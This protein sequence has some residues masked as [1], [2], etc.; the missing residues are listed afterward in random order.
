M[1]H[2]APPVCKWHAP[3]ILQATAIGPGSLLILSGPGPQRCQVDCA[4]PFSVPS[5]RKSYM[6][7][8]FRRT[9]QRTGILYLPLRPSESKAVAYTCWTLWANL[10]LQCGHHQSQDFP[11]SP[12]LHPTQPQ[13]KQGVLHEPAQPAHS[14]S[15]AL[16][17]KRG[18]GGTRAL[19][20]LLLLLLSLLSLLALSPFLDGLFGSL[21]VS[22]H[23]I[24]AGHWETPTSEGWWQD[25]VTEFDGMLPTL[26][27]TINVYR[28][29]A[30]DWANRIV[31]GYSEHG[32]KLTN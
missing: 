2:F 20:H 17:Q 28:F 19:S 5:H 31:V 18:V 11:M 12:R 6:G 15:P 22:N 32:M 29:L 25:L 9:R 3:H 13:Q 10:R 21:V 30:C 7:Y 16:W 14:N 24:K 23:P 1:H 26:P 4:P 8:R 27:T